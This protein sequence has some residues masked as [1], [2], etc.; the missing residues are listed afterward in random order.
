MQSAL[1][2]YGGM[3]SC[4]HAEP[5]SGIRVSANEIAALQADWIDLDNQATKLP[6]TTKN[7]RQHVFPF[8]EM[9]EVILNR[10]L[11][12]AQDAGDER[13][14]GKVAE[15]KSLLLFPA[16]GKHTAFDGWSKG[17]PHF[18]KG[19]Q[20]DH[21]TLHDLMR[22]CTT[23]LA[24]LGVSVHVRRGLSGACLH[25]RDVR[26]HSAVGRGLALVVTIPNQSPPIM[27]LIS[28]RSLDHA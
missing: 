1:R 16:R 10:A 3:L 4:A 17:K 21:W 25:G 14:E 27:V 24:A 18:D 13:L 7:K 19:C 6:A 23:N 20:I 12:R 9:A 22:T 28:L 26:S 11:S 2:R 5:D 15:E 8:G